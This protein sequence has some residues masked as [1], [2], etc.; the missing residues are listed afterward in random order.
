VTTLPS[1]KSLGYFR[2]SLTGHQLLLT[3]N[4][5]RPENRSFAGASQQPHSDG[6][7][8]LCQNSVDWWDSGRNVLRFSRGRQGWS[9][10]YNRYLGTRH[11]LSMPSRWTSKYVEGEETGTGTFSPVDW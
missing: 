11:R 5:M 7:S 4:R 3:E 6:P 8:T 2:M 1:D 10:G 9:V